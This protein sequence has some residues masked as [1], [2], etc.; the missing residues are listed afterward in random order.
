[1][2][3]ELDKLNSSPAI[4]FE[5]FSSWLKHSVYKR[6]VASSRPIIGIL[7]VNFSAGT[8]SFCLCSVVP[9]HFSDEKSTTEP[10]LRND[11]YIIKDTELKN[12]QPV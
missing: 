10:Q 4:A 11:K 3:L 7:T 6:G 9:L 8:R 5:M 12:V 1:M 2:G